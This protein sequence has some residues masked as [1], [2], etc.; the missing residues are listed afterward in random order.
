MSCDLQASSAVTLYFYGELDAAGNAR[1]EAHLREC[2]QCRAAFEELSLIRAALASRPIVD[3]PPE[4]W[5]GFME[6]LDAAVG[7]RPTRG[8]PVAFQSVRARPYVAALAT[9]ALVVLV[10]LSVLFVIRARPAV[11][12]EHTPDTTAILA[13]APGD[14]HSAPPGFAAI[15]EEHFERSK[16]VVLGL[17]TKDARNTPAADWTYERELASNLL[18]DTRVYRI[19]AENK[20]MDDV[21]AVMRDLELV[22]LQTSLTSDP[23]PDALAQI[24][25]LIRKRDLLQKMNAV[26][27]RGI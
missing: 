8:R 1:V 24:Q 19:A 15:S 12:P 25:R 11:T 2:A 21:A 9:A 5:T 14:R 10:T 7:R 17:A 22:L 27:S 13:P 20:G 3:A 6:R 16:L 4:G 18:N 26:T 23:D